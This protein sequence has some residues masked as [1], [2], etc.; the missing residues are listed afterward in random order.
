VSAIKEEEH[1]IVIELVVRRTWYLS[2]F[3]LFSQ[4]VQR[5]KEGE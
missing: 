3:F 5:T 1:S 4:S 2:I